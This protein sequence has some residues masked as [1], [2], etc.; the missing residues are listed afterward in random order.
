MSCTIGSAMEK[1][2]MQ[3]MTDKVL[4]TI[5]RDLDSIDLCMRAGKDEKTAPLIPRQEGYM[6]SLKVTRF[7]LTIKLKITVVLLQTSLSTVKDI[8]VV[9]G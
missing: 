7:C 8:T 6:Q 9:I 4:R 1:S 5:T 2:V 3:V